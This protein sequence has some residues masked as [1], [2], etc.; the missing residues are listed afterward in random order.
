MRVGGWLSLAL[1]WSLSIPPTCLL[2]GDLNYFRAVHS[3][4][5]VRGVRVRRARG[6]N[7]VIDTLGEQCY[8]RPVRL[9]GHCA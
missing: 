5:L 9:G 4:H 8:T 2:T 1:S 3:L 6:S 7:G